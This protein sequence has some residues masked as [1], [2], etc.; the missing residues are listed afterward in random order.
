MA[1]IRK[2]PT[3]WWVFFDLGLGLSEL[4]LICHPAVCVI[5]S[6]IVYEK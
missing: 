5:S 4:H 1:K 6:T 2:R 3:V